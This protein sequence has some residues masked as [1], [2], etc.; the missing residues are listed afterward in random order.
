MGVTPILFLYTKG[1][2]FVWDESIWP[3][4]KGNPCSFYFLVLTYFFFWGGEGGERKFFF[5][6]RGEGGWVG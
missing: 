2:V 1:L 4:A 6:G 5:V 3:T